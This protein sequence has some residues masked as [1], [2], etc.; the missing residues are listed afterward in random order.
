MSNGD[1]AVVMVDVGMGNTAFGS[2][3]NSH[4]LQR[5]TTGQ[6]FCVIGRLNREK[7]EVG[8]CFFHFSIFPFQPFEL[9]L[10]I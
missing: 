10:R 3:K 5:N 1:M 7:G 6:N 9:P 4:T 2:D 8:Q